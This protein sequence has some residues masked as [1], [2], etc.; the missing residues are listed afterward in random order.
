MA[1]FLYRL[2]RGASHRAKTVIAAWVAVMI[3]VGVAYAFGAGTMSSCITIPGTPTQEV[4]DRLAGELPAASGGTGRIVFSTTDDAALDE[5]QQQAISA[6]IAEA[7]DLDGVEEVID[8]FATEAER[9]AQAQAVADGR[10]QIVEGREQI[11]A[12]RAQL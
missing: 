5:T 8:P 4:S 10:T 3:L 9:A 11:E 1:E 12:A 7:N 6:V 2:G